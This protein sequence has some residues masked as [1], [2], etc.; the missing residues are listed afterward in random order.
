MSPNV[1][2]TAVHPGHFVPTAE[3]VRAAVLDFL[4]LTQEQQRRLHGHACARCGRRDGL[5]PGGMAYVRSGPDGSGR[6]GYPVRVCPDHAR[7]GGTW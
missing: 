7:T 6:L 1:Q 4:R 3:D 5:R 2:V